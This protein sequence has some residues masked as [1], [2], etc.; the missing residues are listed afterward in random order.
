MSDPQFGPE[1]DLLVRCCRANFV[2]A[3][4]ALGISLPTLLDW[5]LFLRLA[6]RHRVQGLAWGALASASEQLPA[7][8]RATLSREAKS[9]AAANLALTVE[10][11]DLL[12]AFEREGVPLLFVK[13]LTLGAICY[14]APL[15][16]MGWDIDLLVDPAALSTAAVLL[17]QLGYEARLPRRSRHLQR[18]HSRSKESEWYRAGITVELHSRLADNPLLIP[19][20]DVNSPRQT[21]TVGTSVP[22][23]T[24]A[25]DELLAYLAVHGSSSAWFR[26]KWISDFAALLALRRPGEIDRIYRRSLELGA[27]RAAGQALLLADRLFGALEA[28]PSLR[29]ELATD[30]S[31]RLLCDV[32]LRTLAN[33]AEPTEQPLGTL[34]IHWTQFLLRPGVR[35]KLTELCQQAKALLNRSAH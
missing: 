32:A 28:A 26:L 4:E 2:G 9:I 27:A 6:R 12:L 5:D 19:G 13:G 25:D 1:F 10:C 34:P 22:L 7:G 8:P 21:V 16:K 35:F 14:R 11:R 20:I 33:Q 23:P 30:R 31:T 15:L 3:N 18:W 17:E 29:G 24:L